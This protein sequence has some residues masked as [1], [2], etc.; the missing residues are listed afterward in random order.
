MPQGAQVRADASKN[1]ITGCR[2]RQ[3][4]DAAQQ[5]DERDRGS[6]PRAA[7]SIAGARPCSATR[8]QPKRWPRR[9]RRSIRRSRPRANGRKRSSALGRDEDAVA[10]WPTPSPFPIRIRLRSAIAPRDRQQLGELYRK[11]HGSEKG[12]GDMILAAYDRTSALLDANG[13]S[14]STRSIRISP[15]PSRCSSPS[16][17]WTETTAASTQGQGGGARFLGH[18]VRSPAAP[19]IRCMNR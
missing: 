11:L 5:Q 15:R 3:G 7:L 8:R 17:A 4:S 13:A 9:L 1:I 19:S 18:L 16:P 2:R 12:L 14:A 6:G 10:H